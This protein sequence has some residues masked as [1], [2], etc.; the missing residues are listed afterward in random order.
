MQ[1]G[2]LFLHKQHLAFI[3]IILNIIP[4]LLQQSPDDPCISLDQ[5]YIPGLSRTRGQGRAKNGGH[6]SMAAP[7]L[8]PQ[9]APLL[10]L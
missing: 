1:D 3:I 7:G 4:L 2:S 10:P 9:Y 5:H 6:A 8:T